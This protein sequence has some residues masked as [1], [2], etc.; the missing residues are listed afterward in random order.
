[1]GCF[2]QVLDAPDSDGPN[3]VAVDGKTLRRTFDRAA[4]CCPADATP[5]KPQCPVV[6]RSGWSKLL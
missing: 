5:T 6:L 4:G 3:V 2:A 1:V